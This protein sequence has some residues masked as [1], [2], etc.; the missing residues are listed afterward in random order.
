[1]SDDDQGAPHADIEEASK[2]LPTVKLWKADGAPVRSQKDCA[3]CGMDEVGSYFSEAWC[4]SCGWRGPLTEEMLA[5]DGDRAATLT[6][7]D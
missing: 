4:H 1:M 3:R 2:Q 5:Q 6:K 7:G